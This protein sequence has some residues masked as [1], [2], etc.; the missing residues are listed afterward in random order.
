MTSKMATEMGPIIIII[1]F[2]DDNMTSKM[3]TEMGS[4]IIIIW[5]DN[6]NMTSKMATRMPR[7]VQW[8]SSGR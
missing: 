6:N 1:W 4:I 3:A 7:W 5:F 2:D 8:A